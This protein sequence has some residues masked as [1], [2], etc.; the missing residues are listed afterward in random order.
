MFQPADEEG[1]SKIS[2]EYLALQK[3]TGDL[4]ES[5]SSITTATWFA[6]KLHSKHLI[7]QELLS[8]ALTMGIPEYDKVAKLLQAVQTQVKKQPEKLQVLMEILGENPAL[9]HTVS[10]L[11][12]KMEG[13]V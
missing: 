7:T 1:Y 13:T 12:N 9:D 2:P 3:S 11:H 6:E 8:S 10:M 4:C 5:I